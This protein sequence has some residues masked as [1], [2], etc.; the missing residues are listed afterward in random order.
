MLVGFLHGAI[1]VGLPGTGSRGWM[2]PLAAS[3]FL[4]H[5]SWPVS[6]LEGKAG[7][8]ALST[9]CPELFPFRKGSVGEKPAGPWTAVLWRPVGDARSLCARQ[10]AAHSPRASPPSLGVHWGSG[11]RTRDTERGLCATQ[12][13]PKAA[14]SCLGMSHTASG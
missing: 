10:R 14:S 4:L 1:Y 13:S 3:S 7:T 12:K 9:G 6:R 2:G 11:V 8:S 5:P